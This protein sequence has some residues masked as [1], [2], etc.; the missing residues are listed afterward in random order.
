MRFLSGGIIRNEGEFLGIDVGMILRPVAE[1]EKPEKGPNKS[2][3]AKN[4][5]DEMPVGDLENLCDDRLRKTSGKGTG[6]D[7]E[8]KSGCMK[9]FWKPMGVNAGDAWKG[10]GLSGTK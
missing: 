3:R 8:T 6:H 5:E 10:S 1:V 4:R 2:E 9:R 7:C